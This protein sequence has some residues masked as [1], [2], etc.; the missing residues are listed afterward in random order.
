MVAAALFCPSEAYIKHLE[1]KQNGYMP[2][3][4]FAGERLQPDDNCHTE[5]ETED[6]IK[7]NNRSSSDMALRY[8]VIDYVE[9]N[10]C[11][12]TF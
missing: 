7:H 8:P 11:S 4:V 1:S 9:L 6:N 10:Y 3:H 5:V 12:I 2:G